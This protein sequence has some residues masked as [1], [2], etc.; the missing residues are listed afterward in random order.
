MQDVTQQRMLKFL[1]EPQVR[2][3][4]LLNV[5]IAQKGL[6]P[7]L[8]DDTVGPCILTTK[9]AG[10]QAELHFPIDM[11]VDGLRWTADLQLIG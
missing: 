5:D 1:K 2:S 11:D 8:R 6:R 9:E 4:A 10:G 7:F 3:R